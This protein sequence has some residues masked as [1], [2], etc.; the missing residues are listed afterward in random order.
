MYKT[1]F[2]ECLVRVSYQQVRGES[3][4]CRGEERRAAQRFGSS[5]RF[6]GTRTVSTRQKARRTG[7]MRGYLATAI[8]N[9]AV[10]LGKQAREM[11]PAELPSYQTVI[12]R[13]LQSEFDN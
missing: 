2:K 6:R 12:D 8:P 4:G 7:Y 11:F 1:A 10:E 5:T 13:I 3:Q 9:D